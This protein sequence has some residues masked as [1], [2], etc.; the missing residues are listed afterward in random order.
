M[1]NFREAEIAFRIIGI[2]WNPFLYE[3]SPIL[4]SLPTNKVNMHL[5]ALQKHWHMMYPLLLPHAYKKLVV[6][7]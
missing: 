5:A 7:S 4:N 2:N 3:E 1:A 6:P